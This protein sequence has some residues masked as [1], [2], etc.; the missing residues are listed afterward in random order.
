MLRKDELTKHVKIFSKWQVDTKI[1]SSSGFKLDKGGLWEL[2]GIRD[3]DTEYPVGEFKCIMVWS[4]DLTIHETRK[5]KL[6]H[7]LFSYQ[8]IMVIPVDPDLKKIILRYDKLK[9]IS[10]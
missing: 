1:E 6:V 5:M 4:N 3:I 10:L 2:Q 8:E 7:L 9:R